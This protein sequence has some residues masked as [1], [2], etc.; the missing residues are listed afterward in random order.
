MLPNGP[1]TLGPRLQ[2]TLGAA[3]AGHGEQSAPGASVLL[4]SDDCEAMAA[5]ADISSAEALALVWVPCRQ[6][7]GLNPRSTEPSGYLLCW[8]ASV[9]FCMA[10]WPSCRGGH[11]LLEGAGR[12][13]GWD[14]QG[15]SGGLGGAWHLSNSLLPVRL[16][17]TCL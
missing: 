7:H 2:P 1:P 3:N 14:L 15:S 10:S 16:L 17:T 9:A 8:T 11:L 4:G 6:N 12:A 5:E 13:G